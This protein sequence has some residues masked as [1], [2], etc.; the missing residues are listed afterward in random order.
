MDKASDFGTVSEV[1]RRLR[2]RVPSGSSFAYFLVNVNIFLCTSSS[3]Y[4]NKRMC[5]QIMFSH[6]CAINTHYFYSVMARKK[7][8]PYIM[9]RLSFFYLL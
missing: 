6:I 2:V 7:N 3:L 1:I 9:N 8:S 4:Y 5:L